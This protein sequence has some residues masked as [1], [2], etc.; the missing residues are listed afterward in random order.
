VA[1][2]ACCEPLA[3]PALG[4]ETAL[5]ENVLSENLSSV[6]AALFDEATPSEE[7]TLSDE[8]MSPAY[9]PDRATPLSGIP[10]IAPGLLAP[11]ICFRHPSIAQFKPGMQ[12]IP[13]RAVR[14]PSSRTDV[15]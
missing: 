4:T 15:W 9:L 8:I 5:S 10:D 14:E 13:S 1:P 7:A 6:E 12:R 3:E 11:L 2:T